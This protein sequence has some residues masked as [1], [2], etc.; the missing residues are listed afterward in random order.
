MNI[1]QNYTQLLREL[2]EA[3]N[4][5]DQNALRGLK[6]SKNKETINKDFKHVFEENL[7]QNEHYQSAAIA[8][9]LCQFGLTTEKALLLSVKS[10][11]NEGYKTLTPSSLAHH[12][13]V[14]G[15]N[16]MP[17][18]ELNDNLFKLL[19]VL[20]ECSRLNHHREFLGEMG[21]INCFIFYL[22][23]NKLEMFELLK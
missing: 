16:R 6:Q 14:L 18:P 10:L 8:K 2:Q 15:F 9:M 5:H 3:L 23:A 13:F 22:L 21:P 1:F 11:S 12:F 19:S 7:G 20:A 17:I 4:L